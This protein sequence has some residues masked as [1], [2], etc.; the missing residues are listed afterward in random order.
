MADGLQPLASRV[1]VAPHGPASAQLDAG[2]SDAFF[3]STSLIALGGSL[4]LLNQS[5]R[6]V[7]IFSE[8]PLLHL[9]AAKDVLELKVFGLVIVYGYAFFKFG[10]AYRLYNYAA[11]LIGAIPTLNE[12]PAKIR[13][14]TERAA[15]VQIHAGHHFHWGLRSLFFSIG[16]LGW[17][18]GP[19][20]FFTT[21]TLIVAVLTH[22]QFWSPARKALLEHGR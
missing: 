21:S 20:V 2:A 12:D 7:V 11:I 3:A 18:L 6:I 15:D 14:A 22:R 9:T 1:A 16:Y 17:F 19:F 13:L 10:W 5:D 8:L 4:T